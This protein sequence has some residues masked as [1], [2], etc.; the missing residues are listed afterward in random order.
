MRLTGSQNNYQ[1]FLFT[2]VIFVFLLDIC[3]KLCYNFIK[4][5]NVFKLGQLAPYVRL[6]HETIINLFLFTAVI[7]VFHLTF[8]VEY[9]ILLL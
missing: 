6:V 9:V 7:F 4:V 3:K 2:A 8:A 1:S 5:D